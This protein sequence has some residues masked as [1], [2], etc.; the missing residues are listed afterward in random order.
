MFEGLSGRVALVTGAA[1]GIGRSVAHLFADAGA[2]VCAQDIDDAVQ[3]TSTAGDAFAS[4]SVFD[5]ADWDAC[6]HWVGEAE[7]AHGGVD[8]LINNAG[9]G[10]D[11]ALEDITERDFDRM[12]AVHVGGSFATAQAAADVMKRQ[13]AGTIVNTSSRWALAGHTC[14]SDYVAAKAAILGLT[15]AWAKELAPYRIRVN[16]IAP[17]GV[18]TQMVMTTLG[19]DGIR[20]EEAR[21][22]LGR[23]A[24]P[25]EMATSVAF[26]A[27]DEAAFITGQVLSPNGG[28]TI[29]GI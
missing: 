7:R 12:V 27:S 29:A 28:K 19:P 15:K 6:A 23:W 5:I 2:I 10:I 17:G 1:S 18:K 9:I 26:L 16:A 3:S 8:I 25:D 4:A 21:T 24:L 20:Q 13:R 14:A 22:P 11:R